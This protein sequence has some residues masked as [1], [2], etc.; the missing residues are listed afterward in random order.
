M[1]V[2]CMKIYQKSL[3]IALL[4]PTNPKYTVEQLSWHA[5]SIMIIKKINGKSSDFNITTYHP[6][7]LLGV[8][9]YYQATLIS[10]KFL[11]SGEVSSRLV[12]L[13]AAIPSSDETGRY[14][15]ISLGWFRCLPP[16]LRLTKL[17]PLPAAIPSSDET[18][19]AACRHSFVW[20]NRQVRLDFSRLVPLPA[21]I[22]SSDETGSAACRHSFVWRN[23]FRCLPPF[24]RLTKQAGTPGFL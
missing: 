19:S 16:F 17:V 4:E 13:P 21:A 14:A 9:Q 23:W 12:P 22:P 18:G 8:L 2:K 20:R 15:W 7:Q 1:F 6:L 5:H 3:C 10:R 11:V 24:L